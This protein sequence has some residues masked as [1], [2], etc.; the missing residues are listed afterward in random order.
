M[1]DKRFIVIFL[2]MFIFT[3][4]SS[5]LVWKLFIIEKKIEQKDNAH[6]SCAY[7]EID[8]TLPVQAFLK[9]CASSD[10]LS[11]VRRL[12]VNQWI[13]SNQQDLTDLIMYIQGATNYDELKKSLTI[14]LE[15]ESHKTAAVSFISSSI[16]I[17]DEDSKLIEHINKSL[18]AGYGAD[19]LALRGQMMQLDSDSKEYKKLR[20]EY[21]K[22]LDAWI[23]QNHGSLLDEI[24]AKM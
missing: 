7:Q 21:K 11:Y 6:E 18:K 10:K 23:N 24:I 4:I 17:I 15:K 5:Y 20:A 3:G 22:E 14:G 8:F 9:R 19:I 16:E 13:S 2:L 12:F 1:I